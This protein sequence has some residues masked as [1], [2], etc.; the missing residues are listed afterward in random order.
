MNFFQT[1][2]LKISISFLPGILTNIKGFGVE[3]NINQESG[4]PILHI[5][6][7]DIDATPPVGRLLAYN[8]VIKMW[9]LGLRAKGIVLL[10]SGKPIVLCAIDWIGISNGSIRRLWH[11]LHRY[12]KSIY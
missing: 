10:G 7:F 12:C 4:Q 9:D 6:T 1:W 8:P 3:S 5:A 2:I 11:G